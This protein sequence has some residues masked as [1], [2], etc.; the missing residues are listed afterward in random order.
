MPI[1]RAGLKATTPR[2]AILDVLQTH[3]TQHLSAEEIYQLLGESNRDIGLATVYRVLAQFESAGLVMRHHF[4]G[5]TAVFELKADTH[6]DHVVCTQCGRIDEFS[7]AN[8]EDRQLA[9]AGRLGY[10]LRDHSLILYG[11][12]ADCVIARPPQGPP[13][14]TFTPA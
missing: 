10:A 11:I 12:C 7:D 4:E 1:R 2:C 13:K 6:H 14:D 9:V 3:S 8:I 5:V